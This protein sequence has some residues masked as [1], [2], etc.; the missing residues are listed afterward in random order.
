MWQWRFWEKAKHRWDQQESGYY[1]TAS[2]QDKNIITGILGIRT[3]IDR[4]AG[5]QQ[6]RHDQADRHESAKA[7]RDWWTIL[8]LAGAASVAAW[9]ILQS[10]SD[11][12]RALR[13]AQAVA[14]QQ[15][16]DTLAALSRTDALTA[17]TQS[18]AGETDQL[19][20]TGRDTAEQQLRAY[21][22]I[23]GDVLLR[24]PSCNVGVFR[25]FTPSAEHIID[26]VIKFKIQNGGQTPAYNVYIEDSFYYADDGDGLPK[27]FIYQIRPRTQHLAGMSPSI[28]NPR[29][30]IG[31]KDLLPT[32]RPIEQDVMSNIVRSRSHEIT[33]FY[34]GNI[35]YTDVFDKS[36]TTP[37][38]FQYFPNIPENAQF[39]NCEEHNTPLPGG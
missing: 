16:S 6:A 14:A 17:A 24:C 37:F 10:H 19:V 36:R 33:L 2:N 29:G 12:K 26:N 28:E 20:K 27:G 25:P 9:G 30:T 5:A 34:Y 38:C 11:T 7:K 8:A 23:K 13:D 32:I 1:Q 21:V 35:H 18:Q 31:P 3:V 39:P 22:G 4:V 15:H